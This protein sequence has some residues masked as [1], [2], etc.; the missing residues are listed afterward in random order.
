M[1][2]YLSQSDHSRT[3]Q[4]LRRAFENIHGHSFRDGRD[5]SSWW[6]ALM[7]AAINL[8]D[9]ARLESYTERDLL[10]LFEDVIRISNEE[11]ALAQQHMSRATSSLYLSEMARDNFLAKEKERAERHI[12]DAASTVTTLQVAHAGT[13]LRAEDVLK[14]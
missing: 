6:D 8:S 14:D 5:D 13:V 1:N 9:D 3:E 12:D 7:T 4:L 10:K 2:H 11:Y